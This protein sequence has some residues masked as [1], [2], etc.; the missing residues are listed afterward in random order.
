MTHSYQ[1][2][3]QD[4]D[5]LSVQVEPATAE[6]MHFDG[7]TFEHDI[8]NPYHGSDVGQHA[9]SME[10]TA[11]G[12]VIDGNGRNMLAGPAAENVQKTPQAGHI[13]NTAKTTWGAP[14]YDLSTADPDK[15]LV[16]IGGMETTLRV[17]MTQGL[18]TKDSTGNMSDINPQTLPQAPRQ[19]APTQVNYMDETG[20]SG[21][22]SLQKAVGPHRAEHMA[23]T[24]IGEVYQSN[25]EGGLKSFKRPSPK[26][27]QLATRG[28]GMDAAGE[29][30]QALGISYSLRL[31]I[32]DAL[33]IP[34]H[35]L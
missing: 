9:S 29:A 34:R 11:D 35:C 21:F 6:D 12:R 31:G 33:R 10:V 1:S 22:Q 8:G 20:T 14:V 28:S 18:I 3:Y 13:L 25:G 26:A 32:V 24:M 30:A 5:H 15:T 2:D 16:N 27:V 4:A 23:L 7:P 19:A 17:A